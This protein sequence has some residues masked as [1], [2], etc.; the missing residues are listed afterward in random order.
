MPRRSPAP[1]T[2]ALESDSDAHARPTVQ[3]YT[4]SLII[5]RAALPP[6]CGAQCTDSATIA[7]YTAG[8]L[9]LFAGGAQLH[10][11]IDLELLQLWDHG[12][13]E[14]EQYGYACGC[15]C[16]GR[17]VVPW[18]LLAP[19]VLAGGVMYA[20]MTTTMSRFDIFTAWT[21]DSFLFYSDL[22]VNEMRCKGCTRN[23]E[24]SRSHSLM[25]S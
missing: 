19:V 2:Y 12:E 6:D 20:M 3:S 18:L 4:I 17:R 14:Y 15:E 8:A 10:L 1:A 25:L 11:L 23:F 16:G 24:S 9:A 13:Y 7:G 22:D 5:P 21:S